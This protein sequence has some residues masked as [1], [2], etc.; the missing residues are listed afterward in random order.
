[1]KALLNLEA[2]VGVCRNCS[3]VRGKHKGQQGQGCP[4]T[5]LLCASM[6]LPAARRGACCCA[7]VVV[8]G[9][10]PFP[11]QTP[12]GFAEKNITDS[13]CHGHV[14]ALWGLSVWKQSWK[15]HSRLPQQ[16]ARFCF[17]TQRK[18]VQIIGNFKKSHHISTLSQVRGLQ[19]VRKEAH[20]FH[21][22]LFRPLKQTK[23]K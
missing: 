5:F 3:S 18:T 11:G 23:N 10:L 2:T 1:M 21:L 4:G 19:R 17:R 22:G 15:Y 16:K 8:W 14:G 12:L 7:Q 6:S 20:H 9:L 13:L